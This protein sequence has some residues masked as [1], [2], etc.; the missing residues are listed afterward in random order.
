MSGFRGIFLDS[1]H[2]LVVKR[3][4]ADTAAFKKQGGSL[5]AT[6]YYSER[7][8]WLR[9]VPFAIA[10]TEYTTDANHTFANEVGDGW[11]VPQWRDWVIWGTKAAGI[12]GTTDDVQ[13]PYGMQESGLHS[14][15]TFG[16]GKEHGLYRRTRQGWDGQDNPGILNSPL[17][18][19]TNLQVSN[20]GDLGT[21][22]RAS[23]DIKVHNLVDLEA[24]EM[25]YMV[26]GMSVLIE[27]GWFHP[28]L[29]VDPINIEHIEDGQPLAST[30]L[31][32]TEIL[33]KSFGVGEGSAPGDATPLYNLEEEANE[34]H[35]PLGPTAGIYDGLL[36]VVT[37]F[38]WTND[39][40]GGY[41]CV[42]D[43]I[44]PGSLAVG[45]P[46]D[47]YAL[48]GAMTID[49]RH[50]AI[51]D[52]KTVLASIKK[53]SRG[54]EFNHTTAI[55]GD[56]AT[57]KQDAVRV[58]DSGSGDKLE[59]NITNLEISPRKLIT[60]GY[61]VKI[62][63]DSNT[64]ELVYA[65][66]DE[67]TKAQE[68]YVIGG[69]EGGQGKE[70][71]TQ[72]Y[73]DRTWWN[74]VMFRAFIWGYDPNFISQPGF[75]EYK[76]KCYKGEIDFKEH[77]KERFSDHTYDA[78]LLQSLL[79]PKRDTDTQYGVDSFFS[80]YTTENWYLGDFEIRFGDALRKGEFYTYYAN[81]EHT[82][83]Q[84]LV[85]KHDGKWIRKFRFTDD[86]VTYYLNGS[87]SGLDG[88]TDLG[89]EGF[90]WAY[91]ATVY[92]EQLFPQMEQANQGHLPLG[93]RS[94]V[95]FINDVDGFVSMGGDDKDVPAGIA[96]LYLSETYGWEATE[97]DG[98]LTY[99]DETGEVVG[100]GWGSDHGD[101]MIITQIEGTTVYKKTTN[102][103]G[104]STYDKVASVE[105]SSL[106]SVLQLMR[107]AIS[108]HEASNTEGR[109]EVAAE[110]LAVDA[111]ITSNAS[112][113]GAVTWAVPADQGGKPVTFGGGRFCSGIYSKLHP[114]YAPK[115][116]SPTSGEY[117]STELG[118]DILPHDESDMPIKYKYPIGIVA[119]SETYLSWRFIEDY[120]LS[121]LYM[122]RATQPGVDKNGESTDDV[123]ILD[124]TFLSAN[125]ASSK[126][127]SALILEGVDYDYTGVLSYDSNGNIDQESRDRE[128]YLSQNIINHPGLRSM[129]PAVCILPGQESLPPVKLEEGR[130]PNRSEIL[131]ML[132]TMSAT[133]VDY[134]IRGKTAL[135]PFRGL[136][137]SG[138]RDASIGCLRNIMI[139]TDLIEEAAQKAPNVRKFCMTILDKVNKACGE[140]WKFKMLTNSA[141]GKI[142]IIDENYTPSD[143]VSDYGRGDT[144]Y[145]E[146]TGVYLFSGIGT[147][148]ILQSVKIQSKIPSELATMA[149]YATIGSGNE[150]GSSIQMFNMYRAGVVDR[151]KSISNI[152]ILG[153]ETGSDA[154]RIEVQQALIQS[155][156]DLT[157]RTRQTQT[158]N[159]NNSS[160]TEGEVIAKQYVRRYIHGD[161]H[162][163]SGY[164]P[165][166][167][168]E[169]SLDLHGISGI[170]MG[171]AIMIKTISEGGIL[172]NRYLN[173]VALQA[174][175]VN[176]VVNSSGWTTS[177]ETLMRPLGDSSNE[178]VTINYRETPPPDASAPPPG[179]LPIGN[180]YGAG[181]RWKV[182]SGHYRQSEPWKIHAGLDIGSAVG[183]P[184][185]VC[186]P[187]VKLSYHFQDTPT[188]T[189]YGYYI[190]MIGKGFGAGAASYEIDYG[191]MYAYTVP[192]G[193][194]F[195]DW[196]D[197]MAYAKGKGWKTSRRQITVPGTVP[198]GTWV[199]QTG[200]DGPDGQGWRGTGSSKGKH[201][202]VKIK[203]GGKKQIVQT[204]M[205]GYYVAGAGA[206]EVGSE[207]KGFP[208]WE[209]GHKPN[210]GDYA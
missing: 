52:I 78:D 198:G 160:I 7:Q 192:D 125:R 89:R 184:V 15:N 124:T 127:K 205:D 80:F 13:V 23:F 161:T 142:S 93:E 83:N 191:H 79:R 183:T 208:W 190:K 149:Y 115:L 112:N 162:T 158:S 69:Y 81:C 107:D 108:A 50:I 182:N 66:T 146:E 8:A 47:S 171:N 159:L 114:K 207:G 145:N 25:M 97:E 20:K 90:A 12:H 193:T 6:K 109:E 138:E 61:G 143:K 156:V 186:L 181:N 117:Y 141:L 92:G 122:P 72:V 175:G 77:V 151:L 11:S 131:H 51:S 126:E 35:S 118:Y 133:D 166:M 196:D 204:I 194:T 48:G 21:I 176:H 201:L 168:I 56:V 113:M 24:I 34:S 37:K 26:P 210:K 180:P 16:W 170:Y 121:E 49:E 154:A 46:A 134:Y 70:V 123:D 33:K 95:Y 59:N 116:H 177:I 173:N 74:K 73:G 9:V 28:D 132:D 111:E 2:P 41:D 140:P 164:R 64:G 129:N 60:G 185:Q 30:T 110:N 88:G 91:G 119:Y 87:K 135:N 27:W 68:E 157:S 32:N 85:I 100:D 102:S 96:N 206:G 40:N 38:N 58:G 36:G 188:D 43:V 189:G 31:I 45:I 203:K 94:R 103:D 42:I 209:Q 105:N 120:L 152:T 39:G 104:V 10:K 136:N 139:N 137:S 84:A 144:G 82:G 167:P 195:T 148:N 178:P 187:E 106:D 200:G 199:G 54:L 165:P 130:W 150:K 19:I 55:V 99:T 14:S 29:K 75:N 202:H 71:I 57:S 98:E 4:D 44:S 3:L 53:Q 155:Y 17:P 86:S 147:D 5:D 62:T 153:N 1:I 63:K 163:V 179:D 67:P 128:I 18:G 169:V 76:K 65:I 174:T 101:P 22:R 197:L 172:P